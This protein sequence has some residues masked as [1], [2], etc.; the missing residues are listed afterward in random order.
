MTEEIVG[1][2]VSITIAAASAMLW[3]I[4]MV[5]LLFALP[6]PSV[7]VPETPVAF[8]AVV[9]SPAITVKL[10]EQTAPEQV[11]STLRP[12]VSATDRVPVPASLMV[13]VT[14]TAAPA[15]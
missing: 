3:P 2:T 15:L 9:S 4:G 5:Q 6:A 10:C 14:L 11:T 13:T 1:A 8:S 12:V 7:S